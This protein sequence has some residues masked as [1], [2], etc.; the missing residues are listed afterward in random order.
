[1]TEKTKEFIN[2]ATKI[3]GNKYNYSKVNY[4]SVLA[5]II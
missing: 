3:H 4:T 2:K 5:S 1:M